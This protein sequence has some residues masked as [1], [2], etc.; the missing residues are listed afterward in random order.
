MMG[1]LLIGVLLAT[2][3]C[4]SIPFF[5]KD[6]KKDFEQEDMNA[7]EQMLYRNAQRSLRSG[8]YTSAI[9]GLQRLEARFP[10]GRYAEQAQLEIIYAQFMAASYDATRTAADRFIRLHPNNPHVDYAYYLKGLAAYS[11]NKGIMDRIASSDPAKRDMTHARDAYA[12]FSLLLARFPS[13][14]Y[15]PDA[16]QRMLYLRDLIARSELHIADYY[17]R[18]RAY[19]A[20]A[21]R[22]RYVVE[23]YSRSDATADALAIV[24]E[25]N[26]RL[27]LKD[28][29]NDALR[30]LALNFPDYPAFDRDGNLVLKD[31]VRNRDRSWTNLITFG[32]LDRPEVP[33]PIK[34]D[35]P[36]GAEDFDTRS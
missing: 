4:S 36:A 12:D 31:Q 11:K 7:T 25:A 20:A 34:I 19:A 18:R 8:N 2:T 35:Q 14:Q 28:A 24:I 16:Y 1:V 17:M 29:A 6:K 22:A 13:S 26:Y 10:F 15:A 3:A 32:L 9:E 27:G 23:T 30:V 5:G 33:P 21:N